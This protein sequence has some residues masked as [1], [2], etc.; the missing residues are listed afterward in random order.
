MSAFAE[1]GNRVRQLA[2]SRA[3]AT[4]FAHEIWSARRTFPIVGGESSSLGRSLC[5]HLS[6]LLHWGETQDRAASKRSV[7]P[8]FLFPKREGEKRERG[9]ER[10]VIG[11]DGAIRC[12]L[13]LVFLLPPSLTRI[14]FGP[15]LL[16]LSPDCFSPTAVSVGCPVWRLALKCGSTSRRRFQVD[17][18]TSERFL[19]FPLWRPLLPF[20]PGAT[21]IDGRT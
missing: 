9:R 5:A 18:S 16:L 15:I 12:R 13:S 8:L 11:T 20:P 17:S 3:T 14:Y 4:R 21:I 10:E 7:R 1:I 6:V 2:S 19:L